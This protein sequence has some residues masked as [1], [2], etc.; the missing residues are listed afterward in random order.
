MVFN[1]AKSMCGGHYFF[2]VHSVSPTNVSGVRHIA[3]D[4]LDDACAAGRLPDDAL[5]KAV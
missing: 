5:P 4:A 3:G 2:T 1:G